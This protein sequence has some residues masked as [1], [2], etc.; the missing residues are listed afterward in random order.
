MSIILV[1]VGVSGS[2]KT[3]LGQALASRLNWPYH[4]ADDFH[5]AANI[6]K[7]R[8]GQPL[9]D[10]D[11]QPWLMAL[12]E[13]IS[14]E[15]AADHNAVVSCSGLKQAYRQLLRVNEKVKIISLETSRNVLEFRLK[16]RTNHFFN[17]MLLDSQ[18]AT[19]EPAIDAEM[20]IDSNQPVDMMVDD[21]VAKL[22][23]S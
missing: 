11:R 9:C 15:L 21:I 12:R 14:I 8:R 16:S 2:G 10:E 6:E 5:P 23:K 13:K 19:W 4:E 3:A 20:R 1:I 18:L 17:A 22:V 7:M